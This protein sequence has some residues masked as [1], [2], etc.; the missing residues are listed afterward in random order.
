MILTAD[1]GKDVVLDI[2][3]N[4]RT[5]LGTPLRF[6]PEAFDV[7][8]ERITAGDDVSI[9][10]NDSKAGYDSHATGGVEVNLFNPPDVDYPEDLIESG[11]AGVTSTI[12]GQAQSGMYFTHFRPDGRYDDSGNVWRAFGLDSTDVDSTYKFAEVRAGDDIDIGHISTE[13]LTGEAEPRS[14]DLT[15]IT[16]T[17]TDQDGV[18]DVAI[19][20]ETGPDTTINF[21]VNTDV[22]WT[23]A[24][25]AAELDDVIAS[26]VPQIFLT[27]NGNIVANELE[28]DMLVGH[29]HSTA[30]DVTLSTVNGSILDALGDTVSDVDG[31]SIDI[32]ANGGSIGISGRRPG[33]R[34]AARIRGPTR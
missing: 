34:L 14:Y 12:P 11:P 20:P 8:I 28:G 19:T 29:I 15:Q 1:A 21:I 5:Q 16:L 9:V 3:A 25:P 6:T 26:D 17:D 24:N 23:A 7:N 13:G 18:V 4:D 30:G 22:D 32:D 27:T 10:V 2:T 31:R 33:D